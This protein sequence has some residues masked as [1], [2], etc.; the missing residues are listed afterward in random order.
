MSD[1]TGTNTSDK[2]YGPVLPPGFKAQL[3]LKPTAQSVGFT[4][5]KSALPCNVDNI[6]HSNEKNVC[7]PALPSGFNRNVHATEEDQVPEVIG[8][9][10]P[11]NTKKQILEVEPSG[12][13]MSSQQPESTSNNV[14]GPQL[15]KTKDTENQ[16]TYGPTIPL[17][18]SNLV[19]NVVDEDSEEELVGPVPLTGHEATVSTLAE[20]FEARAKKMKDKLTGKVTI[21]M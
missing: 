15:P 9:S 11:T 1:S 20:E 12:A 17:Q 21:H 8:P 16:D 19:S 4:V 14:Y 10:V 18:L 6:E 13:V 3:Q 5:T 7:G 2:L